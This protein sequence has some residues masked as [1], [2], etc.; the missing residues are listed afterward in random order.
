MIQL[1]DQT[2]V[3]DG[4]QVLA[5]D[6]ARARGVD[7]DA[8]RAHTLTHRILAAHNAA[9]AGDAEAALHCCTA[10]LQILSAI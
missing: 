4:A 2:T 6:E 3:I 9:P 1:F 7:P 8:A 5:V 10:P